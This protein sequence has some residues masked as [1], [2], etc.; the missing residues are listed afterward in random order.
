[1]PAIYPL[2]PIV[3]L[4]LTDLT[5]RRG[6]NPVV[7]GLDLSIRAGTVF[8]VVGPN[9]AGK[10]SLLR[11]IA[12][13]DPPR[14]GTVRRSPAPGAPFLYFQSEMSLPASATVGDWEALVLR[15][16]PSGSPGVRTPLWPAV[17]AGRRVG[18]LSTGERKRLLLDALFR[19]PGSLLLDEPFE[20][21]SPGAKADLARLMEARA[22][23]DVVVVATNQATARAEHDGGLRLEGGVA[24]PLAPVR[25]A[26]GR[27]AVP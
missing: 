8:W 19:R 11:A 16:L 9:G 5:V 6:P 10:T 17:G 23:T 22:R 26:A 25:A 3:M 7:T 27:R 2:P 12:G 21:L 4:E 24:E 1:M 20:H 18:R 15:L 13:L 14:A